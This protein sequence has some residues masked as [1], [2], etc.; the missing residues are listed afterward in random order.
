MPAL[1]IFGP[2]HTTGIDLGRNAF[3]RITLGAIGPTEM[4]LFVIYPGGP[5]NKLALARVSLLIAKDIDE[6]ESV[7]KTALSRGSVDLDIARATEAMN[8]FKMHRNVREEDFSSATSSVVE[9]V[10]SYWALR[11]WLENDTP[12]PFLHEINGWKIKGTP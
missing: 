9:L 10:R 5:Q 8:L 7:A 1:M 6:I 3:W 2:G 4:G 11:A 12:G